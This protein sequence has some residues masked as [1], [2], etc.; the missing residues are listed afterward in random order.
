MKNLDSQS[1]L[2]T[3]VLKTSITEKSYI[4]DKHTI[5][6]SGIIKADAVE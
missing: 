3:T 4:T 2:K 5:D 1:K 6:L